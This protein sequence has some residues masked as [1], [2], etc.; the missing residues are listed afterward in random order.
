M[1]PDRAEL[2]VARIYNAAWMVRHYA[3]GGHS[4]IQAAQRAEAIRSLGLVIRAAF[5]ETENFEPLL[6]AVFDGLSP[7]DAPPF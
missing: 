1:A 7:R 3:R 4:S 5:N 6:T 2:L